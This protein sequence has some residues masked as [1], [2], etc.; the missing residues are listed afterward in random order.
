MVYNCCIEDPGVIVPLIHWHVANHQDPLTSTL[1][2]LF[3]MWFI[4][5]LG[6]IG[7]PHIMKN[8]LIMSKQYAQGR[9]DHS[10][11]ARLIHL[12]VTG[13]QMRLIG[14]DADRIIHVRIMPSCLVSVIHD[15]IGS[16]VVRAT[17]RSRRSG[18]ILHL[19][20]HCNYQD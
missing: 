17:V 7:H 12:T 14:R 2:N 3:I 8:A 13:S 18:A 1:C 15:I 6:G 11:Q 20:K 4:R 5:W 9:G 19:Y 10:L 16:T